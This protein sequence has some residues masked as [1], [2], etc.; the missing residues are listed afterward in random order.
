[1][2]IS[3]PHI[4]VVPTLNEPQEVFQPFAASCA[5]VPQSG[6]FTCMQADP[7]D[8]LINLIT[9]DVMKCLDY[10]DFFE[11]LDDLLC[12]KDRS[13]IREMCGGGFKLSESILQA[14][15]FDTSELTDILSVLRSKGGC[16]DCEIL[17][18]VVESSRLKAE[19]WRDRIHR[20][21]AADSPRSERANE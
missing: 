5:L 13:R 17:Y 9:L 18:N 8:D 1:V 20:S 21:S 11:K 14:A 19:Y 4:P 15:G 12:P 3:T 2:D 6:I 10:E 7:D 16:C